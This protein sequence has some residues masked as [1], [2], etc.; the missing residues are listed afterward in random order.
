M[1]ASFWVIL[2][3]ILLSITATSAWAGGL[4]LWE[5]GAPDVGYAAAGRAAAAVDAST[6][7]GNPAGMTRLDQSE[8]LI[9]AMPIIAD[10]EFQ[11]GPASTNTG[12][13]GGQA[14]GIVPGS[15]SFYVHDISEDWKFGISNISYSGAALEFN[16]DWVGRYFAQ[17][18][19][20]ATVSTIP[21]VGYRINDQ[22]S[23]G[24]GPIF[25]YGA[26]RANVKINGVANPDGN[27]EIEDKGSF[28]VGGILGLLYEQS[29]S[30][31]YGLTYI[32]EI[33]HEFE[34]EVVFSGVAPGLTALL[35][36]SGL[37][38]GNLKIEVN[39]PQVV[40]LS[41][42]HDL[43]DN[44]AI[45]ATGSWQDWS[46]FSQ[47]DIGLEANNSTS[48]TGDIA[49]KDVWNAS[50]G[51]LYKL[52]DQW[53]LT[54]GFAYDSSPVSD[55]DRTIALPVDEQFRYSGGVQYALND[56]T[57]LGLAYTLGDFGKSKLNQTGAGPLKGTL[58]GEFDENYMH[59][60][61]MTYRKKF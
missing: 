55:E 26:L 27:L 8:L 59:F 40:I 58:D 50:I 22:F 9:G 7:F 15:G 51:F 49:W 37:L 25:Q 28:D 34:S 56:S 2:I 10:V 20:L 41:A 31:R 48:V 11:T 60:I 57:T 47:V 39:L 3:S 54:G 46:R 12:G 16:L 30:T 36:A 19:A 24:G 38:D 6:A 21:T 1:K 43:T 42:Y 45:L 33:N 61:S 5:N 35:R 23:I 17:E 52:D 29:E 14:G 4:Y 32:S 53:M 13:S 44:L 18:V